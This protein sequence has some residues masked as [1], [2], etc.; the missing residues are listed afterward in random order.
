M[1]KKSHLWRSPWPPSGSI[2]KAGH[3]PLPAPHAKQSDPSLNTSTSR[4]LGSRAQAILCQSPTGPNHGSH[5][6]PCAPR[7][8]R[9]PPPSNWRWS[10]AHLPSCYCKGG[11][12]QRSQHRTSVH[13]SQA[14]NEDRLA[15]LNGCRH[16]MTS[17]IP[18]HR[19][20]TASIAHRHRELH[21]VVGPESIP[22]VLG[23]IGHSAQHQGDVLAVQELDVLLLGQTA[24]P[25]IATTW[26]SA[27]DKAKGFWSAAMAWPGPSLTG[28]G[29]ENLVWSWVLGILIRHLHHFRLS[30]LPSR[31]SRR[32]IRHT[33][34]HR[35]GGDLLTTT[36]QHVVHMLHH[37]RLHCKH[38]IVH[39]RSHLLCN[40]DH[41]VIGQHS[42]GVLN[43]LLVVVLHSRMGQ[44]R[45]GHMV[46]KSTNTPQQAKLHLGR[47]SQPSCI[48]SVGCGW[49]RAT[50][51]PIPKSQ[52][53]GFRQT[54]EGRP[55]R[56]HSPEAVGWEQSWRCKGG[57]QPESGHVHKPRDTHRLHRVG[58]HTRG[59]KLVQR[60][61]LVS[62]K[63]LNSSHRSMP[64]TVCRG[65]CQKK[66]WREWSCLPRLHQSVTMLSLT[67]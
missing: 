37:R 18:S 40:Q 47:L 33:Q 48:V 58:I 32:V 7:P 27:P 50:I 46:S 36:L 22:G 19:P 11:Q 20:I 28:H 67:L 64:A 31:R 57:L 45:P 10:A 21:D 1:Q 26:T 16:Q 23:H 25:Q 44:T 2:C 54:S 51:D 53:Q 52:P 13:A 60:Q 12:H 8:C 49:D 55:S 15:I 65:T 14:V 56:S 62:T 39:S 17:S 9:V 35:P 42:V 43:V 5:G 59:C 38:S 34:W 29:V 4:S 24:Q 6:H 30:M 41:R 63:Q 61:V 3:L 66:P